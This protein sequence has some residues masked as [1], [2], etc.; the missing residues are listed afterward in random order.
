MINVTH[1]RHSLYGLIIKSV[2]GVREFEAEASAV[3]TIRE[4]VRLHRI[5]GY[6]FGNIFVVLSL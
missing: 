6:F 4:A 1:I 2:K 5:S 3:F